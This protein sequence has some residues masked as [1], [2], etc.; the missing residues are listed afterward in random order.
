MSATGSTMSGRSTTAYVLPTSWMLETPRSGRAVTAKLWGC[1]SQAPARDKWRQAP[2]GVTALMS[3]DMIE[4]CEAITAA[5][6]RVAGSGTAPMYV[7]CSP[8]RRVGKTLVAR[9]LTEHYIADVAPQLTNFLT[10]HASVA[11]ISDLRGQMRLFDGLI[12]SNTVPKIIDVSH[13]EFTNFFAVAE[14]I[15]L[16]EEAR[17]RS[18]EPLILFP[19]DPD[20]TAQKAYAMLRRRFIGTSLLPVRNLTVAKGLPYGASFPHTSTLAVSLEIPVLGPAARARVDRDG[21]SFAEF[22]RNAPPRSGF[23]LRHRDELHAWLR[24][25]R[26]QFREI[27]L[28]LMCEQILTALQ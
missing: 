26:F 18:I 7:I 15:G 12:E 4:H 16:F 5:A 10:D 24:R 2:V 1:H 19:I 3:L 11:H 25:V 17:R 22:A 14:K 28:G 13:R 23:P 20:P 27:E 9:L 6:P 8:S 21:F